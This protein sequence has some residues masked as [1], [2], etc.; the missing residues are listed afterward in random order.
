MGFR[1]VWG[2]RTAVSFLGRR[3]WSFDLLPASRRHPVADGL[4]LMESIQRLKEACDSRSGIGNAQRLLKRVARCPDV[5]QQRDFD[6]EAW[7]ALLFGRW[8]F[9]V[10]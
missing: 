10:T 8:G 5:D 7:Y 9:A 6:S 3:G 4:E 1:I 2:E